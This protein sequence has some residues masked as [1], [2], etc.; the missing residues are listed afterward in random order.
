MAFFY[1]FAYRIKRYINKHSYY[2]QDII[3]CW[4]IAAFNTI[5]SK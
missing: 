3:T 5:G 2:E 4:P 1:S